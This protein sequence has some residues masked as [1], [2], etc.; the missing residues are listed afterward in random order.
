MHCD[1]NNPEQYGIGRWRS[2]GLRGNYL[3]PGREASL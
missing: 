3:A 1:G 2:S